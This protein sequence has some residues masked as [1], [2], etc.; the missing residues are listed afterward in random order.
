MLHAVFGLLKGPT[1]AATSGR[2]IK[3]GHRP[4]PTCL[5]RARWQP[6]KAG[7][8]A[9]P[10][11]KRVSSQ[12]RTREGSEATVTSATLPRKSLFGP[13]K[14]SATPSFADFEVRLEGGLN[15][16]GTSVRASLYGADLAPVIVMLGGISANRFPCVTTQ[17]GP[18]WWSELAGDRKAIDPAHCRVLGI[19][20][21]ADEE[22][23]IAP[24]PKEQAEIIG[25]ALDAVGV[26][27]V[28]AIIGASYGAMVALALGQ[29]FPER[30]ERLV[31][32]SAG[33]EPDPAST[34]ARDIQRRIVALGLETGNG[35][36]ALAIARG[37]AMLTY[38]SREEFEQ[39]FAGGI[40]GVE[41][42]S[43]SEPGSYLKARGE[44]YRAIMSPGRFL[45]L[46]ASIDRHRVDPREIRAPALLIGSTSDRL[47]PPSQMESLGRLYGGPSRLQ[48]VSSFFGHD[49]FLKDVA[50][51]E[52]HVRAFLRTPA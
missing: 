51:F 9:G 4:T 45:S 14:G 15:R 46:S 29:H 37:L 6:I 31:I 8:A 10:A 5:T 42:L 3:S 44:A 39:R 1:S 24:S 16:F 52:G 40:E 27:R 22:G 23:K 36:E 19:E 30:V 21:A 13:G 26:D 34:A 17:K 33:A 32:V 38:R 41:T 18:G 11:I 47:V 43:P 28:H 49:M 35:D 50:Q 48:F 12:H 25:L 7:D 20:F 2:S